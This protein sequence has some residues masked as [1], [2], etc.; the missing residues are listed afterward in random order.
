MREAGSPA[1]LREFL[2][3]RLSFSARSDKEFDADDDD[4]SE[5]EVTGDVEDGDDDDELSDASLSCDL[6]FPVGR[7][8]WF[9]GTGK[10]RVLV[11]PYIPISYNDCLLYDTSLSKRS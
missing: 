7:I 1:P 11:C 2:A 3:L 6:T 4:D 5:D 10:C 8:L 9:R